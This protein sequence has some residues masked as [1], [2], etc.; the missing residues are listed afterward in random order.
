LQLI[1]PVQHDVEWFYTHDAAEPT[2]RD[3]FFLELLYLNTESFQLFVDLFAQAFPD[4]LNP[5]L[6]GD[7]G[8][9]TAQRLSL[10]EHR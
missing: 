4:S 10:P 5:L 6:P 7:I 8:A 1:E 2:A 9:H 3:R